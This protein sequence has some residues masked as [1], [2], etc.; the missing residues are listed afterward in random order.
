MLK[1]IFAHTLLAGNP[2]P[3][4]YPSHELFD[5][6]F[7]QKMKKKPLLSGNQVADWPK[8][9]PS[10]LRYSFYPSRYYSCSLS[11]APVIRQDIIPVQAILSVPWVILHVP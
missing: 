2:R 8:I 5:C 7:Q 10:F 6:P 3:D 9:D 1:I 11:Y 4:E